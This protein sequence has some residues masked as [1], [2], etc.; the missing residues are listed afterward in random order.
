MSYA[1]T[2]LQQVNERFFDDVLKR[3]GRVCKTRPA[4]TEEALCVT[5]V[6]NC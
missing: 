3:C 6:N 1:G 4:Q 5:S 2:G